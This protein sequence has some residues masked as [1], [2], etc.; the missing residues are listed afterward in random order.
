[1]R[2][3]PTV[4]RNGMVSSRLERRIYSTR[5]S[6]SSRSISTTRRSSRRG[7][8]SRG[9][10]WPSRRIGKSYMSR[11]GAGHPGAEMRR[12][13]LG[14]RK[15]LHIRLWSGIASVSSSGGSRTRCEGW[16]WRRYGRG[17]GPIARVAGQ[18]VQH[19]SDKVL[20]AVQDSGIGLQPGNFDHLF[21][22]LTNP[23]GMR[24]ELGISH[25]T[26]E[27][28]GR[29]LWAVSTDCY[30]ATF[31]FTVSKYHLSSVLPQEEGV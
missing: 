21:E 23:Q 2:R 13:R 15:A 11:G 6:I 16:R 31:Q 22:A 10:R 29:R 25:S 18:S 3:S 8:Y 24:K 26:V 28:H 7:P 9:S 20:V 19:E 1:M 14:N 5:S 4:C 17:H 30:D 27:D 12:G